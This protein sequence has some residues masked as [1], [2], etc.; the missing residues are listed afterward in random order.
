M[1]KFGERPDDYVTTTMETVSALLG[2][3]DL[4]KVSNIY[5]S[6]YATAE[7][8]DI[9]DP[10]REVTRAIQTRFPSLRAVYHG[11]FKTGGQALHRAV[12]DLA[13]ERISGDVAVFGSEKMTHLRPATVAG[14]LG[15]R[16]AQHDH[17]YGAT[18]PALGALV[19]K[20]YLSKFR[21]SEIALHEVAAKNHDHGSR[22]PNAH[23]QKKVTLAEV[24]RSPLIADPLR[25][26]HCAPTSDG[27]A[28]VLLSTTEGPVEF[29]GWG[30]GVD[31]PLFQER[32]DIA[33]FV[34]T[35][36]ACA[37]A[38]AMTNIKPEDINVVEVHDAFTS[39]ELINLEEMGFYQAGKSCHALTAGEMA[40][41]SSRAVNP[42]G[43]MKA[44][45][46]PIAATALSGAVEVVTQ[47]TG[48]AGARQ[49]KDA[50]I[51]I[52]QSV[53]GVSRD[54]FIFIIDT[55]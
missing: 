6:S 37:A 15:A 11:M 5:L 29:V 35:R 20:A 24:E 39:F 52:V 10:F 12:D 45:G 26:L 55:V 19:T 4:D 21:I 38:Y 31:A 9:A 23:F 53:G 25:R 42:S 1:T 33:Q 22:N 47:L 44:R 34:A 36:K 2:T 8:C 48:Q 28:A 40:I 43:G 51:G 30:H 7:L 14:I 16:E 17:S 54:S 49:H 50:K 32:N 27:A 13:C 46:H 3:A 18:L 41:N